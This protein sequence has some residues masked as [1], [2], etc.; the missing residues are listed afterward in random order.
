MDVVPPATA[1]GATPRAPPT[2]EQAAPAKIPLLPIIAF[3]RVSALDGGAGA[4]CA[5]RSQ[6]DEPAVLITVLFLLLFVLAPVPRGAR[7]ANGPAAGGAGGQG[8]GV[9]QAAPSPS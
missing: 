1:G 9:G 7:G 6:A 3:A 8:R 4:A 2:G 5:H